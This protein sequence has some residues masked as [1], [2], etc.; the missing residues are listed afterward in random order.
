METVGA[1]GL[2]FLLSSRFRY[3][4]KKTCESAVPPVRIVVIPWTIGG[5]GLAE[6]GFI[7]ESLTSSCS[8]LRCSCGWGGLVLVLAQ[9]SQGVGRRRSPHFNAPFSRQRL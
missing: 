3:V 2:I 8:I 6:I 7:L 9:F 5:A 4:E 1:L